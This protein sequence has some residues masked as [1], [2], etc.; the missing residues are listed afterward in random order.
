MMI[1]G[2][3]V[4]CKENAHQGPINCLK[5]TDCF[6][7][8]RLPNHVESANSIFGRRGRIPSSLGCITQTTANSLGFCFISDTS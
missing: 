8:V 7:N 2:K 4:R 1:S 3:L 6:E 5:Y